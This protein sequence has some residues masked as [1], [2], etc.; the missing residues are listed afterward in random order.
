MVYQFGVEE[1]TLSVQS[2]D[3]TTLETLTAPKTFPSDNHKFLWLNEH[4][5]LQNVSL[6]RRMWVFLEEFEIGCL[7][8]IYESW[9]GVPIVPFLM[10]FREI[11]KRKY[12]LKLKSGYPSIS[13][14][15]I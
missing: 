11:C 14:N 2:P 12:F 6:P 9:S 10:K 8:S 3:L 5:M 15:I 13:I 1:L 7:K 4:I